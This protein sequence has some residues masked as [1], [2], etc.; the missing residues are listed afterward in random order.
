MQ[1]HT[2]DSVPGIDLLR[3]LP[4]ILEGLFKILTDDHFE[5]RRNCEQVLDQFL[6]KITDANNSLESVPPFYFLGFF[7][8]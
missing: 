1:V 2:L 8:V 5:I 4:N 3:F 7:L 6:M